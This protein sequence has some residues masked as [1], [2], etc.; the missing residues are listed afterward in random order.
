MLPLPLAERLRLVALLIALAAAA[1]ARAQTA[2]APSACQ[3]GTA[4]GLLD[5]GDVT[6]RVFNTGS[7]FYGNGSGAFY[8]VPQ[9]TLK[10]PVYASGLWIGGQ[11]GGQLRVAGG[12]YGAASLDFTFW[13]GPLGAN[14]RPVDPASC[15]AF[16]R[17]YSVSQQDIAAYRNGS[18]ATSDLSGWPVERGAPYYADVNRNGLRDRN[19]PRILR[20]PGDPGYGVG[21]TPI[22][23]FAG[24]MPDIVGTQGIW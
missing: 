22:D 8:F 4:S 1:P 21:G 19:E 12:T 18:S 6:A 16:D 24:Q 13:P 14:G 15:A 23:L 2:P 17:I 9:T 20:N 11:V 5:I 3:L 7:L 10:S